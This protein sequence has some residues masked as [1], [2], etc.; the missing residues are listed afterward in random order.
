MVTDPTGAA[1]AGADVRLMD[2]NNAVIARTN[3]ESDGQHTFSGVSPGTYRVEM[4]SPGF[5]KTLIAGLKLTPGENHLNSQLQIGSVAESVEVTAHSTALNTTSST[6]AGN[7]LSGV[8]K[9]PH[10]P[11]SFVGGAAG[12]SY[13]AGVPATP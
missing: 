10:V 2:E 6:L 8:A 11:T 9:R 5:R 4:E 12:G 7:R 3:T 1:V 13:R